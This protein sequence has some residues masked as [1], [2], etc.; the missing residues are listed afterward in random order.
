MSFLSALGKIA[1]IAAPFIP[2]VGPAASLGMKALSKAPT[3]L[4]ALGNVASNA[5]AGRAAGREKE[6]DIEAKRDQLR[7][8]QYGTQQ[9]AEMNAGQLDLQ[10]KNFTEGARGGRAKQALLADLIGGYQPTRVSV[11]GVKNADISG[12]PQ[13]GAGG[14]QAMAELSR[15]ALLA[16]LSP[17]E[18][19][20]GKVM[21]PPSLS[22][23]PQAGKL[24]SF[25]NTLGPAAAIGGALGSSFGN[26]PQAAAPGPMGAGS[27]VPPEMQLG[28]VNAPGGPSAATA[29]E[30]KRL[31][32]Q[33][34]PSF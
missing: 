20:G 28:A 6:I 33:L 12:G 23:L 25:L 4:S 26:K 22:Q 29:A 14:K 5:S 7:N 2:G 30:L 16:Q 34:D 17:D 18:F 11:A 1:G 21:A 15:Q 19:T 27:T 32:Q 31:Q 10:R 24:D 13:L 3:A 8:Q 9:G